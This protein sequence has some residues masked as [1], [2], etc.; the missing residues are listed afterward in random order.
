[1]SQL[2]VF[3]NPEAGENRNI[4]G[5]S[6]MDG[7]TAFVYAVAGD[8]AGQYTFPQVEEVLDLPSATIEEEPPEEPEAA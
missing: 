3:T 6:A 4:G 5:H 8:N 1:M 2:M 7:H